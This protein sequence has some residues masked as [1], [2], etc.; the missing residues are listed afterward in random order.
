MKIKEIKHRN[1]H[2][3]IYRLRGIFQ[4]CAVKCHRVSVCEHTNRLNNL[5]HCHIL[6]LSW[7]LHL[8]YNFSTYSFMSSFGKFSGIVLSSI[9]R[10]TRVTSSDVPVHEQSFFFHGSHIS[11]S[12]L[13]KSPSCFSPSSYIRRASFSALSV[14]ITTDSFISRFW[15]NLDV[16]SFKGET[17]HFEMLSKM[18][19]TRIQ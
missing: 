18:K 5:C 16:C 11:L 7:W 3:C 17:V 4:P 2:G 6:L 1:S 9:R 8:I 14:G 12:V 15:D 10:Q 19:M 13:P